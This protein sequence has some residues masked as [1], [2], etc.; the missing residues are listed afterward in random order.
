MQQQRVVI[1][2]GPPGAG[3]DTQAERLVQEFGYVQVPSSA[4]IRKKFADNPDD[5][6]I[7]EQKRIFDAGGLN[8]PVLV[9]QWILEFAKPLFEQGKSLVF[10]G[11][12]RTPHEGDVELARL[13]EWF[14]RENVIITYLDIDI[15]ESKHRIANR[16]FCVAHGH[17]IPGSPEFAHLKVCPQDQ[18]DLRRRDLDDASLVETR[19][20][21]FHRL[22]VPV[23]DIAMKLNI[24][25]FK[26]DGAK[27]I[28]AVHHDIVGV[29]E[30]R[31]VPVP[32]A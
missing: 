6:V 9:A 12:P 16:R 2:M 15:E 18:S 1:L 29:I 5:P 31:H 3:K 8:D 25:I 23:L 11:S 19:H 26:L 30:G 13:I 14:G 32:T 28:E 21:E 4:I 24:P 17:V 22:T 7:V 10:S 20:G 27:P